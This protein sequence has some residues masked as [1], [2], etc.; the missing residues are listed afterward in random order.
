[1]LHSGS[2]WLDTPV[3]VFQ[4]YNIVLTQIGS[5]LHLN[6]L[7]RDDARILK[8]MNL[9]YWYVGRLIFSDQVGFFT[10]GNPRSPAHHDP[11]LRTV[12][13]QLNRQLRA[14]VDSNTLDLIA[15]PIIDAIVSPPRAIDL[16]V[17]GMLVTL[18]AF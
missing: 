12:V 13:M 7:E 3:F 6:E 18:Y 11:M 2:F 14:W 9:T 16:T 17:V 10:I 5:R 1:M 4:T 15:G 8:S